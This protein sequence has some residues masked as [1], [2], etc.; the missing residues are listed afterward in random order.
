MVKSADSGE[1]DDVGVGWAALRG[2][3]DGGILVEGEVAAVVVVVGD[4]LGH[5]AVEVLL[6]EDD[7]VVEKFST[8]GARHAFGDAVLPWAAGGDLLVLE[9]K[10]TNRGGNASLEDGVVV[11]DEVLVPGLEGEGLS[12]VLVDPLGVW[13][14]G[15]A[16]VEDGASA[17]LN[18]EP[19]V[20][21]SEGGGGDGDEVHGDDAVAVVGEEV[22]PALALPL[23]GVWSLELGEIAPDGALCD[24]EPELLELRMDAGCAPGWVLAGHASVV[25]PQARTRGRSAC[26]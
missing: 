9:S 3:R 16:E 18:S 20:E 23:G 13:A 21:R 12:E 11:A 14:I 6:V 2:A 7:D 4:V 24:L 5:E 15:D 26:L 22:S 10:R 17:M 1:R 19:E 25:G 8:E